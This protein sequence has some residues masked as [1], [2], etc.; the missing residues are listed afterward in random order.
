L[1][2]RRH[3]SIVARIGEMIAYRFAV[4]HVA[5]RVRCSHCQQII[6]VP[7]LGETS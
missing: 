7:T 2:T 4:Q 5:K 3:P 1:K 6:V